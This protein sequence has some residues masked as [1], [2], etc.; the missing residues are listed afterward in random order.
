MSETLVYILFLL[1][2][3]VLIAYHDVRY[4]RIPNPFVLATL[5]AG[6]TMNAILGGMQ[7]VYYQP[8]RMRARLY[9]DVHAAHFRSDG[10]WRRQTLCGDRRR[11]RSSA[12][13]THVP[14]CR[15][16]R[17]STRDGVNFQSRHGRHHHAPST[18]N[19]RRHVARLADAEIQRPSQPQI[20]DS[21]RRCHHVRQHHF[22]SNLSRLIRA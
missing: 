9:L 14:G 22:D 10:G 18:A 13:C 8:G 3:T 15:P 11:H 12:R 19:L 6:V 4:R 16:H 20:H 7:G 1:P 21:L 2:L 5:A 17:R